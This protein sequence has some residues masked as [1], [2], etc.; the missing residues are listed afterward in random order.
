MF[1]LE[2]YLSSRFGG[3]QRSSQVHTA[4]EMNHGY[5]TIIG[6]VLIIDPI[7][8]IHG[9]KQ[10]VSKKIIVVLFEGREIVC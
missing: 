1:F 4:D 7:I 5:K 6:K 8:I 2:N 3:S 10:T 9:G